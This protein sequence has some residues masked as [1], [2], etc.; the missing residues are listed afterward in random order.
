MK[1]TLATLASVLALTVASQAADAVVEEAA[2]MPME[3]GFSWTG[4]YVG[5]F[6]A[7]TAGD[8]DF[9]AND[10]I[11]TD[12][13]GEDLDVSV[14]NSGGLFGG[15]IGYDWQMGNFVVGAVADIAYSTDEAEI[16]FDLGGITDGEVS[17]EL[18]YLGTV[19][20]RVG[21]AMDRALFYAHGGFAY[22]EMEYNAELGG[23]SADIDDQN[24]TGY[25]VGAGIEYAFT[26]NISFQTEYSFVDLGEDEINIDGADGLDLDEDVQFHT[27][28]AAVN[29][30]F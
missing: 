8:R 19:R 3:E 9:T 6:G 23:G 1:L 21:Y 27:I 17:S 2:P 29:F 30:R 22:G 14:T 16:S 10:I 5:G 25:V 18:Q 20:G 13:G 4:F 12:D 26:N 24:K 28:K 15:Q 11:G 7:I